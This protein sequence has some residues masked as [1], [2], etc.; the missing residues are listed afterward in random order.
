MKETNILVIDDD[1]E[2][3]DEVAEILNEQGYHVGFARTLQQFEQRTADR[4]FDLYI[5]DLLLPDGHGHEIIRRV[6]YLGAAGIVV[7]SGKLSEV[8]KVV[9][10]ELGADDYVV[11]PFARSEFVARIRSLLRRLA[12]R[13][14]HTMALDEEATSI[15]YAGWTI[16]PKTR[17]VFQPSGE[18]IQLTKLEFDLWLTFVKSLDRVLSREQIIFSIRGRDWAGYDRSID[19]LVSRMLKKLSVDPMIEENFETVRGVGYMLRS[20]T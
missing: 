20:P 18:K 9:S 11:K 4:A 8:D 6:R 7:L 3:S 10:L 16:N 5:V 19:G 12:T 2:L 15:G 1:I 13:N 17:K 14:V